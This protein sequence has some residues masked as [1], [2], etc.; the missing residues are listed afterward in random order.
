MIV[1]SEEMSVHPSQ[2]TYAHIHTNMLTYVHTHHID[3]HTH[4][5]TH[6]HIVC[7]KTPCLGAKEAGT[8]FSSA[9]SQHQKREDLAVITTLC[10]W[11]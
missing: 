9:D 10:H 4:T 11:C 6:T 3:T 8:K 1:S 7:Y 2:W 5:H